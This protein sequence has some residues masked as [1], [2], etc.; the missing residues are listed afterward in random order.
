MVKDGVEVIVGGARVP[1]LGSTVMFGLGGILVELWKDVMFKL[2]PLGR[3]EAEAMLD[4]IHGKP[5]LEG[6]RGQPPVDRERLLDIL[7]RVSRLLAD[8]PEIAELDLNPIRVGPPGGVT[9]VVDA[10]VRVAPGA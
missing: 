10:R 1:G 4:G 6:F 3:P 9:A 5:L 2:A 8:H 7:M